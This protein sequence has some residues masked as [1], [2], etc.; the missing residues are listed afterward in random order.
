MHPP[1]LA[2]SLTDQLDEWY[3]YL[4]DRQVPMRSGYDPVE[5]RP[6]HGFV[7]HDPEGYYLEFERFNLHAENERLM[8]LLGSLEPVHTWGSA[9]SAGL[10]FKATVL[11]LYYKDLQRIQRFYEDTMGFEMVADQGW[12][13]MYPVSPSGLIGLVDQSRGMH[14]WTQDKALTVSFLTEDIDG[15]FEHLK[16]ESSFELRTPEVS[17][18]VT[19]CAELFWNSRCEK[20]APRRPGL[21][22]LA[23]YRLAADTQRGFPREEMER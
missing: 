15:W 18:E 23:G 7:A 6:H 17:P 8:P 2:A 9:G 16:A 21:K 12:T 5:G 20:G 11:W 13:K 4:S 3:E 14:S 22:A 1:Q 19:S 10:G